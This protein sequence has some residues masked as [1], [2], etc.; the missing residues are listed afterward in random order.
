MRLRRTNRIACA[1][2]FAA[3]SPGPSPHAIVDA[4]LRKSERHTAS[5]CVGEPS[6]WSTIRHPG[7]SGRRQANAHRPNSA[8]ARP[9]KFQL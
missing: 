4:T 3:G 6:S 7:A 1:S 9:R 8:P 5:S 2:T